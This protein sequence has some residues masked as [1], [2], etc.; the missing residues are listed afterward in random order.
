MSST[1]NSLQSSSPQSET[2]AF[3]KTLAPIVIETHIS[4]VFLNDNYAYK[5]KKARTL[6]FVDFSNTEQRIHYCH[7]ELKLNRRTAPDIY[8]EVLPIYRHLDGHLSFEK[9]TEEQSEIIDAVLKMRR[10]DD[11]LLLS[12]LAKNKKLNAPMMTQLA[13]TI[14]NFHH[15]AQISSDYQG[16]KRLKDIVELNRLSEAMVNQVLGHQGMSKLNQHLLSDIEEHTKLLNARAINGKVRRCHGDLHLNN[17]C[18]WQQTPTPFD[19][20]EFNESM[21]TTDVLYDLAF[22]LMDLWHHKQYD[23]ANWLMNRY[24]D[25]NDESDGLALLPLFMSLRASIRAMVIA[26]QAANS[27]KDSIAEQCRKEAQSFLDLATDL[28]TRSE[29]RLVAI[30]GLSGS[31]KS[32]LATA[33][34]PYIGSAPGARVLSTDR[35]RKRLFNIAVEERLPT[36]SYTEASS[37]LVYRTQRELCTAV[38]QAKHSVI[39]DAVFAKDWE[40]E[41]IE[42]CANYLQVP[43]H[44]V[45]LEAPA[46]KLIE[47]VKARKH[48]P[49]DATVSVVEKQ[50]QMDYGSIQWPR[51][52]SAQALKRLIPQALLLLKGKWPWS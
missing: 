25:Q 12:K 7:E 32:T 52:K 45:W 49:S 47:R 5:L 19:C 44:G 10:F 14:A 26:T 27:N 30:G 4:L 6:P 42:S 43:F 36:E 35:I 17:I 23:L 1:K 40:R 31:G 33:L 16:A 50:L 39:A 20:L 48:D 34:A 3:L 46:D 37:N 13:Q 2:I 8:L 51:L 22:L 9:D 21:A 41:A 29:P 18:L 38:L 28:L 15:Q 24:L 11:Q